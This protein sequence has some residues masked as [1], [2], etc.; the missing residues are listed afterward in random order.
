MEYPVW[1][2]IYMPLVLMIIA[3]TQNKKML[4]T[5]MIIR[6]RREKKMSN[7]MLLS[8]VNKLCNISTGSLGKVYSKVV[9]KEIV[10]NWIKVE[11]DGKYDLIN[12]DYVQNIKILDK[13]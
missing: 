12:S 10:D 1:L 6:K 2:A 11:K 13:V 8:C 5:S 4:L 9:V 3:V 7:E